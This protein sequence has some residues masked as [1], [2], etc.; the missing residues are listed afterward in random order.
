M[1]KAPAV[2]D[3]A[4]ARPEDVKAGKTF[5]GLRSDGWGLLTGTGEEGSE[6]TCGAYVT[7]GVWKE[8][9]C[10]NLAAIGKTTNDYPF[11]PSW[12]LIGG[13][14]QWGRKGPDPC[15]AE[16]RMPTRSDWD[17]VLANNTQD[18]VGTWSS[19]DT[20]YSSARKFKEMSLKRRD[21][22]FW[23]IWKCSF[24]HTRP[25]FYQNREDLR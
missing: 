2:D 5:W 6:T 25:L 21:T 11:T 17:G 15:P 20:N 24:L 14:W 13:Y 10:Y 22:L 3:G 8:F 4:G 19:S 16:Y 1:N 9:D 18:V 7:P 12:R 23:T